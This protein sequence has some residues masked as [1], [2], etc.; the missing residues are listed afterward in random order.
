MFFWFPPILSVPLFYG[1]ITVMFLIRFFVGNLY[2]IFFLSLFFYLNVNTMFE[3]NPYTFEQLLYWMS[4][5]TEST[6]TALLT[7]F[8]TVIGFMLTY[9]AATANWKG[10][11][12]ANLKLQAAGEFDAFFSEYSR[13]VVDCQLYASG[14]CEAVDKIQ[15]TSSYEEAVFH[16]NYN[17]ELGQKFI[18][19]RQR[20]S[21]MGVDVHSFKSRYGPLLLSS[22]GLQADLDTATK[23]I[24]SISNKLWINVPFHIQGDENIVKS[25]V[26]QVDIEDCLSLSSIIDAHK[27]EL[28][29]SSGSVKGNLMSTVVG[30][31]IWSMIN[32]YRQCGS[33]YTSINKRYVKAQKGN[34]AD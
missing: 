34:R 20:L 26:D 5:Q 11:L 6:K 2:G 21:S 25:F 29:F 9:A 23:A 31:N 33:F 7:S 32:L 17:Y 19:N 12:L 27:G 1:F 14:L 15:K 8:V 30:F 4:S 18:Q 22:P 13:L 24:V 10:E 28:D 3:I 16:A